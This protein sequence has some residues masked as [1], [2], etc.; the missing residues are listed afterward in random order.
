MENACSDIALLAGAGWA[1][2]VASIIGMVYTRQ[3]L[4]KWVWACAFGVAAFVL[5]AVAVGTLGLMDFTTECLAFNYK[6]SLAKLPDFSVASVQHVG[7][8]GD[9]SR[10]VRQDAYRVGWLSNGGQRSLRD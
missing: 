8:P 5:M 7:G 1:V 10:R 3:E 4:M 9:D 2:L 6:M